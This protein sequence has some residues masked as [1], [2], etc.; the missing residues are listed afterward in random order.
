[1]DAKRAVKIAKQ[2]EAV[3]E[4]IFEVYRIITP[5]SPNVDWHLATPFSLAGGFDGF[6]CWPIFTTTEKN[7]SK[8]CALNYGPGDYAALRLAESCEGYPLAYW[9][10]KVR[11]L[12]LHDYLP[13]RPDK[14]ILKIVRERNKSTFSAH[15]GMFYR[16]CEAM[17]TSL[18]LQELEEPKAKESKETPQV[19]FVRSLRMRRPPLTKDEVIR[20]TIEEN[21]TKKWWEP[22]LSEESQK[23]L[24][25]QTYK[26]AGKARE[27][28]NRE[29]G[30]RK[31][32]KLKGIRSK[33]R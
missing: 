17:V 27:R 2:R 21:K 1:M 7:L 19:T 3:E 18:Y 28:A 31:P 11:S 25:E 4:M 13:V 30:I 6:N 29:K 14:E 33:K 5:I 23:R 15:S 24:A 26:S 32:R 8:Y 22:S 10:I 20:L 12:E 16:R 9:V